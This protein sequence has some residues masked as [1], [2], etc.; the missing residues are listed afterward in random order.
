MGYFTRRSETLKAEHDAGEA[1]LRLTKSVFDDSKTSEWNKFNSDT[2]KWL[3]DNN[4]SYSGTKDGK[5]PHTIDIVP[6]YD[7]DTKMHVR[8]PYYEN[9]ELPHGFV[10]HDDHFHGDFNILLSRYFMRSCR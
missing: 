8:I 10:V 5:V 9:L 1:I 2:R 7:T 3:Y 4:Y 6:V